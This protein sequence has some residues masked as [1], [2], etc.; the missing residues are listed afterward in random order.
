MDTNRQEALINGIQAGFL[1]NKISSNLEYRPQLIT[2]DKSK[3]KKVMPVIESELLNCEEFAISVAFITMSGITP[4]LQT[5][6]ELRDR[7]IH[8]RILTTDYLAFSDPKALK[9][10]HSLE[11]LEVR[12]FSTD[13]AGFGF[14]TKGY[15]FRKEEIYRFIIG[16]SNL[17]ASA[18]LE[19]KEWNT[20]FAL[21]KNGELTEQI[22]SDFDALWNSPNT[23]KYEDFIDIYESKYQ[24]SKAQ[25]EAAISEGV[26]SL[27]RYRLTP[28]N[29]QADFVKNV[30]DLRIKGENRALL[31]SATGTGKTYASAFSI[32][33]EK[34]SRVL[35]LVHRE[36][37]AKQAMMSYRR[38]FG[39]S[40]KLGLYTGTAKRDDIHSVDI[41]FATMQT[42][43]KAENLG[44]FDPEEFDTIIIDEVHRAG[45]PSYQRIMNYFNPK[46]WL[47]M[48]AS[49]ERTD[50]FDIYGL[51]DHNIACEIRLQQAL[52]ENMLCPFHYFGITDLIIDGKEMDDSTDFNLLISDVRVKHIVEQIEYFGY[53]GNRPKGLVFCS[54]NREAKELSEKF[55][56]LGYKT[57]SLSGDDS[58]EYRDECI[59]RLVSDTRDDYLEYIFTV[60]IFNEGVD[61]PEVNQV[62]MLR[63]T[64]SPIIFVQQLGRSLRKADKKDYVVI[65]DF[66]GNYNN[67]FMIPIALSGDRSY[68]KD[69]IRRY[70]LEG[71]RIIPGSSTLH[72]DE[73][74]RKKIFQ[75]IDG[76]NFNDL[77]L[78]KEC[79]K[80]LKFKLGRIPT[81]IDFDTYGTIDPLRIFDS[82]TLGSY[83]MFLK[84]YEPE[85]K[86]RFNKLGELYL[87]YI[88]KKF[89]SG[90]RPHELIM[91]KEL[92]LGSDAVFESLEDYIR[93]SGKSNLQLIRRDNLANVLT[94]NF[95]TGSSAGTYSACIFMKENGN[96]YSIS[97]SFAELIKNP[98]YYK[99]TMEL[100][101]FGLHRY[102]ENYVDTYNGSSFKLYSKYTY[103]DVCRLLNWDKGEVA[104]NIGGYKYDKLTKTYPVFINYDKEEDISDT[105]KYED[106][107]IDESRLIAISKSGRSV[108]SDD[109][110]TA[111]NADSLGV[112][113]DL[114]VRKNKDDKISKEFYYLGRIHATG[115]AKEFIMPN[116][117]SKAV[118][119][120]YQLETPV[121]DDIYDYLTS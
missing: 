75:S 100:I 42:V 107:F 54:R 60:D 66:I 23:Y 36:I 69:S 88:S 120:S 91:I 13:D 92:M 98:D 28:N 87:E 25:R 17:T 40:K 121:R 93:D 119:I 24:I 102:E 77:R 112:K 5:F 101:D 52:E 59:E 99:M 15:L 43:S 96:D 71:A 95:A 94:A 34:P 39:T 118:E 16:S 3:G 68:N 110:Q 9:K 19:N 103:D 114:F 106:R 81:L 50:G 48:T 58:N 86:I 56:T 62:V 82:Q 108:S 84:K 18:L 79:Y 104:L 26:V 76:A 74:S 63:P 7:G 31:I 44:T 27:D 30:H 4:M 2:N 10:L 55:N 11:N 61:I 21:S 72:F 22:L 14:H 41:L 53:C 8:G 90:K 97:N 115:E 111:I 47:G 83:Y 1:D 70:V 64:E 49:P 45:A 67:N 116:T 6:K 38:V 57:I 46:F 35:F 113:M 51:F 73:I 80:Q 85:F 12:L 29:M 78:I 105:T 33:E 65:L 109:V 117:N 37:I 20:R 89:A 32:R